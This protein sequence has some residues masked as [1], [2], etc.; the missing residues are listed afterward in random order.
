[1]EIPAF[2]RL[3]DRASGCMLVL[4]DAQ[5]AHRIVELVHQAAGLPDEIL[6][7]AH[8]RGQILGRVGDP[9]MFVEI[10]E[11]AVVCSSAAVAI[12]AISP[13]TSPTWLE[14]ASM[15]SRMLPALAAR[16]FMSSSDAVID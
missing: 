12:W 3:K 5:P 6:D 15:T 14:V 8:S 16:A 9:C 4:A 10:S 1:M 7:L 11:V 2:S 13:A